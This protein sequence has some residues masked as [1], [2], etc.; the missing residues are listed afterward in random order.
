MTDEFNNPADP[1]ESVSAESAAEE[2]STSEDVTEAEAVIES[3]GESVEPNGSVVVRQDELPE[4]SSE[5]SSESFDG[6]GV[7]AEDGIDESPSP[8]LDDDFVDPM[9]PDVPEGDADSGLAEGVEV[10]GD[11]VGVA[12]TP[13]EVVPP[14]D[15]KKRWYVVKVQSGREESI[16][17]ALE[18]RTRIEGLEHFVGQVV[19][20]TEKVTVIKKVTERKKAANGE[21][22][23]VTKEK[24]VIKEQKKFPGYLMAFVEYNNEVLSLFRET[25]GVGD[26][27]GGSLTRA[28]TPMTEREVQSMLSGMGDEVAE[29]EG[30]IAPP[31]LKFGKGDRVK[32]RDGIF[33][34]LDGEVKEIVEPKDA[35]ETT[36]IKIEL[37]IFGRPTSVDLEHWQVDPV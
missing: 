37:M 2:Q 36:R 35:K 7:A 1:P 6:D 16:K 28:P 20:P 30:K 22:Q 17:A 18:R 5:P 31:S 11:E 14:L 29:G 34:G 21:Y 13:D 27:V 9:E 10:H 24:R 12:I 15:D 32:V 25:S 19:I 26:F 4:S 23:K 3:T 33:A 8:N